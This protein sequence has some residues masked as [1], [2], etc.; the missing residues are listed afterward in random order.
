MEIALIRKTLIYCPSFCKSS[1]FSSSYSK[2]RQHVMV[3]TDP[4]CYVVW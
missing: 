1:Y 3:D 2:I 4:S